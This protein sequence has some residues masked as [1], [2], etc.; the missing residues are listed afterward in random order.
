MMT[1]KE[2]QVLTQLAELGSVTNVA[3]KLRVAPSAISR[4]ITELEAKIGGRLFHRTGRGLVETELTKSILPKAKALLVDVRR[5]TDDAKAR[6]GIPIGTVTVGL[7]PGVITPLTSLLFNRLREAFP[8][9][10]INVFEG[11][12]GEIDN[13]LAEGRIDVGVLNR[14]R[15]AAQIRFQSLFAADVLLVG[16]AGSKHLKSDTIDFK[17]LEGVPLVDTI[18]PHNLTGLLH[19]L[20]RQQGVTLSI[21]SRVDSAGAVYDLI[22]HSGLHATLPHHAVATQLADGTFRSARIVNPS[23]TQRV[24]LATSTARPLSVAARQVSKILLDLGK[25]LPESRAPSRQRTAA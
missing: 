25:R 8:R 5:L 2:L 20:A 19:D 16:A 18:T 3:A 24:V 21:E 11:Y 4:Q 14:Y 10:R 13:W 15:S 23:I 22:A 1:L 9:I 12:S 17:A 6:C 7:V